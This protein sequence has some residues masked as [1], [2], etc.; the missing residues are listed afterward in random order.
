MFATL[1]T[2]D[3]AQA[4]DRISDVFPANR[5]EQI[6]VQ[7]AASI[8]GVVSQRLVPKI[9]G[10]Q[11]AAFEVLI[12]TNAMRNLIREGKTHQIRNVVATGM[13]D[14][15]RT[16]E[17]SLSELVARGTITF[18]EALSRALFPKE[19]RR[20]HEHRAWME[21]QMQDHPPMVAVK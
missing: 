4:L 1:H 2:N 16:L 8:Q 7:L 11:V 12:A 10:G 20:P 15:M 14:G 13:K 18:E 19:I 17:A 21:R 3:A 5:Q 9:G 6:K